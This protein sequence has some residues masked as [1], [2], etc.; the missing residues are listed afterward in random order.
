MAKKKAPKP[1]ALTPDG[2]K[3]QLAL[4]EQTALEAAF[5]Q[6]AAVQQHLDRMVAELS[7]RYG[8]AQGV[9]VEYLGQGVI[10]VGAKP[11]EL[12]PLPPAPPMEPKVKT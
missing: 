1:G 5:Q 4:I 8:F 11:P 10:K 9:P 7:T 12:R 3:I 2:T 6:R